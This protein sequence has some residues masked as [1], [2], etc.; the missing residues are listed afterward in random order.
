MD[1]VARGNDLL[2]TQYKYSQNLKAEQAA[3]LT[4]SNNI[5]SQAY[6]LLTAFFIFTAE[7]EDLD[8]IGTLAGLPRF[9]VEIFTQVFQFDVTPFDEGY[10]FGDQA[11]ANFRLATDDE[12]K[13]GILAWIITRNSLGNTNDLI[14][15]LAYLFLVDVTDITVTTPNTSTVNVAVNKHFDLVDN[16][17]LRN[18]APNGSNYWPKIGGLTY[19]VTGT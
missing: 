7:G 10:Y 14:N 16:S 1:H 13:R 9:T 17:L 19:N 6:P 5:E 18:I 15:S 8:I 3:F 4:E 11:W 12:Y 2:L